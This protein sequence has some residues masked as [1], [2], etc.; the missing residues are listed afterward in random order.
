MKQTIIEM[1]SEYQ[2]L[3]NNIE[4]KWKSFPSSTTDP[5]TNDYQLLIDKLNILIQLTNDLIKLNG[6]DCHG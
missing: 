2:Q 5:Y 3:K 6:G 1:R 4:E